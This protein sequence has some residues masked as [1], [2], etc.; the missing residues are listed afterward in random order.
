[1]A[2]CQAPGFSGTCQMQLKCLQRS[3]GGN[4]TDVTTEGWGRYPRGQVGPCL[5]LAPAREQ[6]CLAPGSDF[7]GNGMGSLSWSGSSEGKSRANE[8]L[9]PQQPRA[10]GLD[11]MALKKKFFFKLI[12]LRE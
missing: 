4:Q 10:S 6:S 11:P 5:L 12:F 2:G 3:A 1:M 9:C 7:Q 8:F